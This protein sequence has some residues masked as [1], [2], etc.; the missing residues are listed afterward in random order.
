MA[1]HPLSDRDTMNAER[2]GHRRLRFTFQNCPNR[3]QPYGFQFGSRSFASHE[4]KHNISSAGDTIA[5]LTCDSVG[6]L[7]SPGFWASY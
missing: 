1:R 3:S 7:I 4:L 2:S 6:E 5:L